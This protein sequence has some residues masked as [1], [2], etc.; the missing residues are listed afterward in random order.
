MPAEHTLVL[1]TN[2]WI[3]RLLLPNGIAAQAVDVALAWGTPLVSE[4]TLDELS[5]VLS[6]PKFDKYVSRENRQQ[7]LRLLGGVARIIPITQH[8]SACRDPK[9]D[10]FLDVALNGGAQVIVTGDQDLLELH[11]FHG[12]SIYRPA[13]FLQAWQGGTLG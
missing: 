5:A 13:E 4:Y 12:V 10:K 3:S 7:F 9:D 6:L 2:L 8:I 11:P 1:D